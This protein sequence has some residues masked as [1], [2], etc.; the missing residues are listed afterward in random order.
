LSVKAAR[1]G[2]GASPVQKP[3]LKTVA[4]RFIYSSLIDL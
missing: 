4:N 3:R 1:V 2:T